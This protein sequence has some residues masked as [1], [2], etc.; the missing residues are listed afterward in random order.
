[1][2]EIS[3]TLCASERA[4]RIQLVVC[5][6]DGVLT[7][8]QL[9]YLPDGKEAK[10]FNT[11]DGLGIQALQRAGIAVHWLTARTSEVVARRASELKLRLTQGVREKGKALEQ[12]SLALG[13]DLIEIA[14]IGDDW[15]DLPA[16]MMVGLACSVPNGA[17][18]VRA[19]A[20]WVSSAR[21]GEGAV[22][23][24][25]EFILESQGKLEAV[26]SEYLP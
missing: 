9:I 8:G 13:V 25:A 24:L 6:V 18:A 14:Y 15:L 5:D 21:G 22:R 19:R 17:Q 23:E 20:H 1:M 7:N 10:A 3:A 16:L 11:L 2:A 26:I 12:I 4:K